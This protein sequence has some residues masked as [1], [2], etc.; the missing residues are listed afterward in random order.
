MSW[1]YLAGKE[2]IP[3]RLS[4]EDGRKYAIDKVSNFG[5]LCQVEK[6]VEPDVLYYVGGQKI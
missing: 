2:L 1:R 3:Q 5:A 4:G 6:L